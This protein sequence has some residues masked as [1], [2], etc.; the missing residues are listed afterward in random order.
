MMFWNRPLNYKELSHFYSSLTNITDLRDNFNSWLNKEFGK[1]CDEYA[2]TLFVDI[3]KT[4]NWKNT[5]SWERKI[6]TLAALTDD[7]DTKLSVID[8]EVYKSY[9]FPSISIWY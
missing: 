3:E 7:I 6:D 4:E 9:V 8:E 5:I 1:I 2:E